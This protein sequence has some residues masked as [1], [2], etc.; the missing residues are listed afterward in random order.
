MLAVGRVIRPPHAASRFAVV[1]GAELQ[2]ALDPAS[3]RL[4]RVLAGKLSIR[5]ER[6]IADA[7]VVQALSAAAH[8]TSSRWDC[9]SLQ[10][11]RP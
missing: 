8:L 3:P 7:A 6:P 9:G 5:D 2:V 4:A 10:H 1:A 11:H